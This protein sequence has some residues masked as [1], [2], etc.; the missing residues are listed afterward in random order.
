MI[1][2]DDI[3][4]LTHFYIVLPTLGQLPVVRLYQ[5]IDSGLGEAYL[6]AFYEVSAR[7]LLESNML[8][9]LGSL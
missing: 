9:S 7:G 4:T 5:Y 1:I 3:Y 6:K 2:P 8:D